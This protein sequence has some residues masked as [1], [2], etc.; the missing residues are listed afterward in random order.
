MDKEKIK[1]GNKT[2]LVE[3][4]ISDQERE[5]G[6]SNRDSLNENS[7]MLFVWDE[8]DTVCMWMKDTKIPLDLVFID[9]ELSVVAV[10]QGIPDTEDIIEEN[11]I[12]F[13]L[14]VNIDSG[15]QIGDEL[16]FS[17]D[18]SVKKDI[19]VV[20]N[21]N[22]DTQMELDGGERIFS[23]SNT[24]TLIKFAKKAKAT[25]KDSDYKALGKR[26]FKFLEQQDE[27]SPEYVEE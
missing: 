11:N 21:E 15:I 14:E 18:D 19:M 12:L 20:L 3:L 6:L 1:I 2:Y 27:R 16:E 26:V 25:G 4:A 5:Q 8:P 9:E 7:G 17:P 13:V 10:H 23:R 24:K 22:G